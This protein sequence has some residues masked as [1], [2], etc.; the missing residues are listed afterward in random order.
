MSLPD[1]SKFTTPLI[2]GGVAVSLFFLLLRYFLTK[3][4]FPRLEQS[5]ALRVL[6]QILLYGFI[7]ALVSVIL[8]FIGYISRPP[9]RRPPD[10][11]EQVVRLDPV[12]QELKVVLQRCATQVG[13]VLAL[14]PGLGGEVRVSS[15]SGR[16]KDIMDEI[17]RDKNCRWELQKGNPP[18]L[19]VYPLG[20]P[21][22][23]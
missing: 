3:V 6:Q 11:R 8:G 22:R 15:E 5:G 13:A 10:R 16:L 18:V 12:Q 7:L 2:V 9:D 20:D 4:N 21:S 17:C 14:G 23:P 1:I 19:F